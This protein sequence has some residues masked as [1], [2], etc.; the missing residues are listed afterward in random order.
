MT[1]AAPSLHAQD[2]SHPTQKSSPARI[3]PQIV[4][5]TE[6]V[7]QTQWM[8]TLK[9]V[10]AP[11]NVSLLNPGQCIRVAIYST[12]DKRDDF[13]EKT[14][15]SYQVIFAGH[16][17][18]YR[19]ASLSEFKQIK[20]EGGDL[21]ISALNTAGI[22]QPAATKTMASLGVSANH[23]CVPSDAVDGTAMV[24]V[25]VESAS[26]HQTLNTSSIRVESFESG[27]KKSFKDIDELGTFSET[28]Y[29]Q[30][31][32]ARLLP[33]LQFLVA[34]QTQHQQEGQTEIF[35][36]FLSAALKSD[37]IAGRNF[38]T[39]IGAQPSLTRALGLLALRSAG[40][41]ISSV[42]NTLSDEE[43]KKF[44]SLPQLQDPF[45]LTP[46]EDLFRH[47]DML[48]AVFGATGQFEPVKTIS[49]ALSWRADYE[50]FDK[51]RK[52]PNH[53]STVT[54]SIVRGVVYTAAGWSL[55][56]FQTNDPLVADYIDFLQASTETP[57]SV[58]SE[59]ARLST[60]P[61]FTR[62]GGP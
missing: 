34:N 14:K 51:L 61:A 45:D 38:L 12:G 22:E 50:D 56:S 6:S 58:K 26:G 29:R 33:A 42:L 36:A 3:E 49:S 41:D 31:N 21:V 7:V 40:Y 59:L 19:L 52:T 1:G 44:Q 15:L 13:L 10:N 8:D 11:H 28:Y 5:L 47:L 53:P 18:S 62:A 57:Q 30:P 54:P 20:P 48:W 55:R 32:P 27:S 60:N 16:N 35:A 37:P 4:V 25:E 24:D 39:R 46:T 43:Q 17:D 23:W 2:A 9:L